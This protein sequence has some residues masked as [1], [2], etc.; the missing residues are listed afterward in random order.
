MVGPEEVFIKHVRCLLKPVS[1]VWE[2]DTSKPLC[3]DEEVLRPEPQHGGMPV[4]P[5]STV[6]EVRARHSIAP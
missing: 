4:C 2:S 6:Q 5:A 1:S 3:S